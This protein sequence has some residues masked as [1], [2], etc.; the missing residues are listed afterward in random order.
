[1]EQ[2]LNYHPEKSR[3][4]L[5][6]IAFKMEFCCYI[7]FSHSINR[8]YIGYT[9]DIDE[10]IKL[11]NTGYFGGRSYTSKTRDWELYLIIPCVTIE[12]AL[13]IESKIKKMKSRKYIENLKKHPEMIDRLINS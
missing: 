3:F 4:L 6:I 8:Y 11:H 10:R 9:S 12:Q 2:R 5:N 13:S 1:M 7:L